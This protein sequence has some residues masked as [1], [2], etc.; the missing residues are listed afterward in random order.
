MKSPQETDYE[1]LGLDPED[2]IDYSSDI[3]ASRTWHIYDAEMDIDPDK[4]IYWITY[5]PS[6]ESL[7]D[8]D[9]INQHLYS[10]NFLSDYLNCCSAGCFCVEATQLGQ[11]HYHGWYQIDES[12]EQARVIMIKVMQRFAPN[13]VKI[14]KAVGN[15][16]I[17]S[18]VKHGNHLWY[19]KKDLLDASLI[20]PS[21]PITK[22][23][24]VEIVNELYNP[25]FVLPAKRQTAADIEAKVAQYKICQEFYKKSM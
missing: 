12:N 23:T 18:W 20:I 4:P 2:K 10:V 1:V 15:Y 9:F 14:K 13:G 25:F 11:P 5:N 16:K 19:Y 17:H 6:K 21:N 8:C 7:P 24:R 22:N 3:I